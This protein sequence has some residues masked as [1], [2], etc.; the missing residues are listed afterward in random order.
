M[1]GAHGSADLLTGI[2]SGRVRMLFVHAHPDDESL[3]TGVTIAHHAASGHDVHVL[4]CTLGEEGEVIPRRLGHLQGDGPA[5]AEHRRGE[6]QSAVAALG[7]TSHV[8]SESTD[9]P[10][11]FRDSGMVGSGAAAHPRAWSAIPL[12]RAAGA[13]QMV[14]ENLD[15]DVVLTY[16]ASGGYGH[17][18]HVRTHQAT[19]SALAALGPGAPAFLVTLTP[20]SWADA[21]RAWLAEHVPRDAG[22]RV[23][24]SDDPH[25]SSVVPDAQVTRRVVDAA[26]TAVQHTALRAHASQVVVGNGWFAL[27]S[28]VVSRLA[29]REGYTRLDPLTGRPT[30]PERAA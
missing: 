21:D 8:L 4:T 7:A 26:A 11:G 15:P 12:G 30:D 29:G 16:D 24:A 17:P 2:A 1:S 6:L 9:V 13:V 5:L 23:P 28:A 25:L 18:D 10:G 3:A 27:S 19:R 14:V 22:W 20:R